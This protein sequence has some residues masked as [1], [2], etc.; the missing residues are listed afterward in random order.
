MD[1]APNIVVGHDGSAFS[2]D[3]LRWALGWARRASLGVTVVRAW[4]ITTAP[5]PATAELGYVP[6]LSDFADAVIQH[7]EHDTAAI[8]A[9]F[10][11]VPVTFAAPHGAAANGIIELS[12]SA[13]LVVVGPRGRGGFRGLVMGSVA[14]Q[15]TRHS[16][17]PVVV[18]RGDQDPATAERT[19][20]LDAGLQD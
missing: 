1:R 19:V 13:E 9:D 2:D 15:V 8:R 7:L 3:A 17:C 6:P 10:D 14:E 16:Q 4:S 20:R 11:D 12:G 18:V 5:R